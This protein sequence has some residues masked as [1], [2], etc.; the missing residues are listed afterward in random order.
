MRMWM[1]DP[2][3][4][5]TRHILGEHMEIHKHRHIFVKKHSISGRIKP[6]VQIEPMAM[7][8]RHDQLV[9]YLKN[10]KSPY[11]LP[12]LSHLPDEEKYAKVDINYSYSDLISRCDKCKQLKG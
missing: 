6:I 11:T 1:V 5:C 8:K 10:H 12:D 7:K 2:K 3:L 4:M 9:E